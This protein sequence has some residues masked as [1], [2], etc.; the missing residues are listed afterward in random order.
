MPV[1]YAVIN[2]I[3]H[4]TSVMCGQPEDRLLRVHCIQYSMFLVCTTIGYRNK[5]VLSVNLAEEIDINRLTLTALVTFT[6]YS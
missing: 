6:L 3:I 2:S 4:C 5:Y 1:A